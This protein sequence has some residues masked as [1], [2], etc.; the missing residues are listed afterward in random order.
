MNIHNTLHTTA[1]M[2]PFSNHPCANA[3]PI[4]DT[5]ER[6]ANPL[7]ALADAL[8]PEEGRIRELARS[9]TSLLSI[10]VIAIQAGLLTVSP[11]VGVGV[12]LAVITLLI[13]LKIATTLA[14]NKRDGEARNMMIA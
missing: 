7:Q 4:H 12:P 3:E 2:I 8:F 14:E 1:P 13:V 10:W 9:A 5:K 11:L 6:S